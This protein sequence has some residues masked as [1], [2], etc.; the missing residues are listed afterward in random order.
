MG[1]QWRPSAMLVDGRTL[2]CTLLR[3]GDVPLYAKKLP[4]RSWPISATVLDDVASTSDTRSTSPTVARHSICALVRMK[5]P[6][7]LPPLAGGSSFRTV[8]RSSTPCHTTLNDTVPGVV[9]F[10]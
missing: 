3:D 10:G 8:N 2:Y 5:S 9:G 4:F 7:K 1:V 6:A